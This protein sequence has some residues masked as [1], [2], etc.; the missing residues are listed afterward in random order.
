[1]YIV[2]T[3]LYNSIF[4][5]NVKTAVILMEVKMK[6]VLK[7]VPSQSNVSTTNTNKN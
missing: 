1:M 7:C 3:I 6:E 2:K 5:I 4:K